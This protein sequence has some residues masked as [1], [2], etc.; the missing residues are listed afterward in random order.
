MIFFEKNIKETT[1]TMNLSIVSVVLY[2]EWK[3]LNPIPA[4]K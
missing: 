3:T 1:E 2:L 4:R